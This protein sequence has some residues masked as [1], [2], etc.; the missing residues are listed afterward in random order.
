MSNKGELLNIVR[1]AVVTNQD[2]S[3]AVL[4]VKVRL[5]TGMLQAGAMVYAFYHYATEAR[6]ESIFNMTDEEV[7]K[8]L[9]EGAIQYWT[10]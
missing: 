7:V 4:E 2:R 5:N 9:V 6:L 1:F 8:D 3:D 10:R